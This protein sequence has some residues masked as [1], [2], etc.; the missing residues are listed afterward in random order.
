MVLA[1][2]PRTELGQNTMLSA[3]QVCDRLPQT[4]VVRG[5]APAMMTRGISDGR[6]LLLREGSGLI[7]NDERGSRRSRA[8]GHRAREFE[9]EFGAGI[10]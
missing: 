3:D 1:L 10:L 2:R 5:R 8:L 4:R 6:K 9:D 7:S